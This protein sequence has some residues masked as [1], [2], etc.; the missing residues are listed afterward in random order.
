[1]TQQIKFIQEK[2][3]Y[4]EEGKY[5]EFKSVESQKPVNK[6]VDHAEEYIIG[7]LNA[8]VEG[9]I[10]LGINDSGEIKGVTLSRSQRDEIQ[11]NITD[12]LTNID[13]VIP[14]SCY[15]VNIHF[16]HNAELK[17]IEDLCIVQIQVSQIEEDY[18][19]KTSG[20]IH[21]LYETKGGSNYLKK[22]SSCIKLNNK[23]IEEE[24]RYRHHKHLK[25]ELETIN[26]Q[27]LKYPKSIQLLIKKVEIAKF[28]NDIELIDETYKEI[29]L[30][31]PNSSKTRVAYAS[32]HKSIGDLEGALSVIND[33]LQVNK[34][35]SDIL[36]ARG[37]ILLISKRTDEA[38]KSYQDALEFNPDDYTIL[39][40][41][42]I[43]FR[44]LGKYKESIKFF[45]YALL[46]SPTYRAAKYEKKK[47]YSK[48]FQEGI[49]INTT[50]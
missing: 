24:I 29:I 45:N 33:A 17:Q 15:G 7:F 5:V 30:L 21:W 26:N 20:G 19:Y 11:K 10:Y 37:E 31:K 3:F 9:D 36:K 50:S 49:E 1:M 43:T 39:T 48:M 32:A 18:L 27:L 25:K 6:I 4:R 46:K 2:I 47:T 41:I 23:Q 13:P 28:M 38:L 12:K 35:N 40:Q 14:P 44:E 42:G 16:V 34:P 8:S 22:S